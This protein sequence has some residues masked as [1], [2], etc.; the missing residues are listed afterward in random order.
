MDDLKNSLQLIQKMY[1]QGQIGLRY[2]L[3]YSGHDGTVD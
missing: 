1:V 2:F 3:E